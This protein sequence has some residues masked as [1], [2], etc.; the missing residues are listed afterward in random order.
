MGWSVLTRGGEVEAAAPCR[1]EDPVLRWSHCDSG[2][3]SCSHEDLVLRR[4]TIVFADKIV[5]CWIEF[6]LTFFS[7]HKNVD[8]VLR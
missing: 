2:Q 1:S 8:E 5:R 6:L 3:V 4:S 7:E